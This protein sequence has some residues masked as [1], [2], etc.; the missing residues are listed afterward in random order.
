M[1]A[2]V[3]LELRYGR[4][5][6]DRCW[7]RTLTGWVLT[8]KEAEPTN[9]H[10]QNNAFTLRPV[11][12]KKNNRNSSLSRP[13]IVRGTHKQRQV[14]VCL[15]EMLK[16]LEMEESALE[17]RRSAY[18]YEV[19]LILIRD[20]LE[21]I[22]GTTSRL[23]FQILEDVTKQ[24]LETEQNIARMKSLL[25]TALK[26]LI[27]RTSNRVGC[28]SLWNK[29]MQTVT[30]LCTQLEQFQVTE[31]TEDG[32]LMFTD[33][34]KECIREIMLNFSDHRDLLHLGQC[35]LDLYYMT[36]DVSLWEHLTQFHFTEK[37][38]LNF[39]CEDDLGEGTNWETV[40]QKCHKKHGLKKVY[41]DSIG[42]C[43]KC[44]VLH[45][46]MAGHECWGS[47]NEVA[48]VEHIS[49]TE[50]IHMLNL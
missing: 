48:E 36:Q 9:D 10:V 26:S 3:D 39:I 27:D 49:P 29:H 50:L 25:V 43:S 47:E 1:L 38:M 42:L 17:I 18:V 37:Q 20:Y 32:N 41:A 2:A 12:A 6:P 24:A 45:W 13:I 30:N 5:G 40:F 31:R 7:V 8:D 22:S 23:L 46:M 34:P 44:K 14:S 19:L 15:S 28:S 21:K 4:N 33:L 11:G 35:N 16:F